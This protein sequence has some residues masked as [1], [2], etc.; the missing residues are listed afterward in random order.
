MYLSTSR[1]RVVAL[2]PETG[3]EKW[4]FDPKIDLHSPY[5]EGLVNRGVTSWIDA[6]RAEGEACHR[7]IFL[8]TIDAR[9]FALDAATGTPCTDFGAGGQIDLS[10]GVANITRR[11]EY[12]E[13]SAPAVAGDL[14]IVGSAIADN[15][16]V[17]SPSGQV[18]AYEARTGKLR[19]S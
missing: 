2:D 3:R 8:A 6:A 11:G 1:N 17:D 19:W 14:L 15:D 7:R 12:E 18:R 10:R 5:S 16:R 13:T 9:L 4:S